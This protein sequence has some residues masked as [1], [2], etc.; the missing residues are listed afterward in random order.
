MFEVQRGKGNHPFAQI[1][2]KEQEYESQDNWGW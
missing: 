1:E 2:V